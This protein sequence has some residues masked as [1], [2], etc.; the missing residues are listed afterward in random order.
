MGELPALRYFTDTQLANLPTQLARAQL[1]S[2]LRR[3]G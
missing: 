3:A 2:A 1:A